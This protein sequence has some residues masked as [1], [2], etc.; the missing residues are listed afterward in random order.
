MGFSRSILDNFEI[1][2]MKESDD[3]GFIYLLSDDKSITKKIFLHY[4]EALKDMHSAYKLRLADIEDSSSNNLRRLKHNVTDYNAAIRDDL[5]GLITLENM[6]QD[7]TKVVPFVED[8]VKAHARETAVLLLKTYK[9]SSL[10]NAEMTVYDLI[11]EPN[12]RL[13][14]Y[15][16]GIHKVVKL[17]FQPYFLEFLDK[18]IHLQSDQCFDRVLVDYPSLSVVLGHIWNNAIK[19]TKHNSIITITYSNNLHSVTTEIKMLSLYIEPDERDRIMREGESGSWAKRTGKDGHG[20]GMFY[21]KR[22]TELNKGHFTLIAGNT[23]T[24]DD[25]IPYSYNSFRI[26]L[27]LAQV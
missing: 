20:I 21:I 15:S 23:K 12:P 26:E 19:Y 13:E 2:E 25:G 7:W 8:I 16:H 1:L 14:I 10:I 3:D 6:Q 18:G 4:F 17:S 24:Y 22:L 5:T 11:E 27:P 9:N